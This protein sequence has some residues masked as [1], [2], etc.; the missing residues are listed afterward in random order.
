MGRDIYVFIERRKSNQ[1]WECVADDDKLMESYFF[2]RSP[3]LFALLSYNK[4]KGKHGVY[5]KPLKSWVST[6]APETNRHMFMRLE[7]PINNNQILFRKDEL[8][9]SSLIKSLDDETEESEYALRWID[10]GVSFLLTDDVVS[11]PDACYW[12]WCSADEL[13]WA[14]VGRYEEDGCTIMENDRYLGI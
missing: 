6:L 10:K 2:Y 12:N 8:D 7:T 3:T 11:N 13:E 1:K 14:V 5:Q 9:Y 4:Y